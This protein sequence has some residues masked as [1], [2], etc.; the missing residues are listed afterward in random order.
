MLGAWH[1]RT[2][3]GL[4]VQR[5]VIPHDPVL[6]LSLRVWLPGIARRIRIVLF[7]D[8]CW[9]IAPSLSGGGSISDT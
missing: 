2:T 8:S 7:V 5:L 1:G 6:R 3:C 9:H 4:P